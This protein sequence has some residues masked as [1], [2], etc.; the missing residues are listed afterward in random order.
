M[1]KTS[2]EARARWGRSRTSS[3]K[4]YPPKYIGPLQLADRLGGEEPCSYIDLEYNF[5]RVERQEHLPQSIDDSG[6]VVH[7]EAA[8]LGGMVESSAGT[9]PPHGCQD[10]RSFFLVWLHNMAVAE[11]DAKSL[12]SPITCC[13]RSLPVIQKVCSCCGV[14]SPARFPPLLLLL[15]LLLLCRPPFILSLTAK[16]PPCRHEMRLSCSQRRSEF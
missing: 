4:A 5:H 1:S 15:L 6:F 8:A 13:I 16:Q 2:S 7:G 10:H 14:E 3:E 11:R 9:R 12:T